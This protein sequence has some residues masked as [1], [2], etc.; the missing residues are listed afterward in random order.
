[1][2]RLSVEWISFLALDL[3][4]AHRLYREA[5]CQDAVREYRQVLEK[6]P[7]DFDTYYR[8]ADCALQLHRP[9]DASQ[10]LRSAS[11]LRPG[12]RAVTRLG[13]KLLMLTGQ[14]G[15]AEQSISTLLKSDAND[16]AAWQLY[17]ALLYSKGYHRT[18]LAAFD[19]A[20]R[21][22]PND[23]EIRT[24]RASCLLQLGDA[25]SAEKEFS[26]LEDTAALKPER[27]KAAKV[28]LEIAYAQ[29]LF[30]RGSLG[31]ALARLDVAA[32]LRPGHPDELFW[33]ARILLA[34]NKL[35]EAGQAAERAVKAA[36]DALNSRN[37]LIRIYRLTGETSKA[38]EQ[39]EWI[40]NHEQK[41]AG[42]P[43]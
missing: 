41:R 39:A 23:P 5:R 26:A 35:A 32:A 34:G 22:M 42:A 38:A 3:E 33:R 1:M 28:D 30:E 14:I 15:Q 31:Q 36:P 9:D 11:Q 16:A 7:G 37:L 21:G 18:A 25:D 29:L 27:Y 13:A 17:G 19:R 20:L 4:S 2:L 10:A 40:R 8:L 12:D 6:A 43:R 24:Y